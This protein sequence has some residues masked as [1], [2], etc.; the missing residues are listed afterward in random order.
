MIPQAVLIQLATLGLSAEHAQAV[1]AMLSSV[2]QATK[3]EAG[4]AIES[5]RA[6]D[7]ERKA[8]Q[9][10]GK[11]RDVTGQDVTS[12]T[13]SL[14]RVED[15]LQTT[16]ISGKPEGKK[17]N[18]SPEPEKSAP[19]ASSPVVIEL[20]CV[21][22]EP[23]SVS[24]ADVN[25]WQS[26]FPAVDVHQQLNA[27]R[28]WLIA[29]PTRR[30]TRRG[31]RRFAVAWLDRRQNAGGHA[32]LSPRSGAPPPQRTINDALQD[33]IDREKPNASFH[34]DTIE[35]SLSRR[36]QRSATNLVQFD[37]FSSRR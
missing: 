5:R 31:M 19:G 4:A 22:G 25:E 33:I 16:E 28:S 6:S 32:P 2:E 27:M 29:N 8:R 24:D 21:S 35:T 14:A 11:S 17:N 26:A 1:A 13:A 30:K 3:D 12:R 36:D 7:R 23:Y 15:N 34:A 20:P 37:A 9:R 10:H 18:I